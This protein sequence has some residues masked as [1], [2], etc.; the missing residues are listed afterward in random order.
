MRS[1]IKSENTLGFRFGLMLTLIFLC[2]FLANAQEVKS[3]IDSTAIKIGEKITYKIEVNTEKGAKV[4]FP[5]AKGPTFGPLEVFD[6]TAVDTSFLKKQ[7]KL[8][9]EYAL[10][11]FDSGTYV[12]PK[13]RVI[14]NGDT[15]FTD[16]YNVKVRDVAV[17]TTKQKMFPIKPALDIGTPLA[18]PTWLWWVLSIIGVGI[19]IYLF[20][21]ARKKMIEKKQDLPPYE[22]AIQTLKKLDENR[23]LKSGDK[24]YY[25]TLSEAVKRYIDEEIDDRALE[26]TTD[27][28]IILLKAYKQ[29]KEVNLDDR[30]IESL[31]A[32]LKRAD[33]AKFA[34]ISTDK[35]TAR[36]DRQ[37]VEDNI[38][39]FN[40][41]I[42]EPTEEEKLLDEAYRLKQEKKRQ[43]RRTL[44]KVG[45]G[46]GVVVLAVS[47][48]IGLKGTDYVKDLIVSHPTEKLLKGDWVKSE[49]GSL[50]MTISTPQVLTRDMDSLD[51]IFP[52]KTKSEERFKSGALSRNLFIQLT[53]V[54]FNKG[55]DV[56]SIDVGDLL[57]KELENQPVTNVTFMNKDFT[58]LDNEKGQQVFGTF[59]YESPNGRVRKK[60]SYTFLVFVERGGL[61]ELL[62]SYDFDDESGKEIER[63]VMNSVEFNTEHDG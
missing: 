35:L 7:F 20:L 44:V 36:E 51:R 29:E 43:R 26:S 32:V 33:L 48:F 12:I 17:D 11:Q 53:N 54:R 21:K 23:E 22:K 59:T 61:Q 60:K 27:E 14:I 6:S 50:G 37:T 19:L 18:I 52:E 58:T 16:T 40:Q 15:A 8:Q 38:N 4:V 55:A 13:Q 42:P 62:I 10:T 56:D 39:A 57:D 3:S 63:R 9:K 24:L 2:G 1:G 31:E 34:G 28:F 46:L 45:L 30:V 25:S 47:V 49:Y 41:T 5:L